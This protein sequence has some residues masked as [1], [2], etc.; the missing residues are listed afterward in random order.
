LPEPWREAEHD[1]LGE[2]PDGAALVSQVPEP[3]WLL[4]LEP[5]AVV[6]QRLQ[7]DGEHALELA[8]VVDERLDRVGKVGDERHD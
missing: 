4:R 8:D 2:A 6:E 3:P 7:R 1:P 5:G